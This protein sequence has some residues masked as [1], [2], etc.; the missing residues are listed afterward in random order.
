MERKHVLLVANAVTDTEVLQIKDSLLTTPQLS[1]VSIKLSLVHVVPTLPTC[2]LN[3]SSM[4]TLADR[5]Y[6]EA[7]DNLARVGDHLNISKKDQWLIM[8]NLRAEVLRLANKLNIQFILASN[9]NLIELRKALVAANKQ[10]FF[11][12]NMGELCAAL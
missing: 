10:Q 9:S 7:R 11:I 3:I 6:H 12:D 8:G 2:Y 4:I 1:P 5:Y